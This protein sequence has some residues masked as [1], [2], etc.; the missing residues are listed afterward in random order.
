MLL[1]ICPE[2]SN[3]QEENNQIQMKK[4]NNSLLI[5]IY[6]V[7][8]LL[9]GSASGLLLSSSQITISTTKGNPRTQYFTSAKIPTHIAPASFTEIDV[10]DFC[11]GIETPDTDPVIFRQA[12]SGL[13]FQAPILT[14]PLNKAPP[15]ILS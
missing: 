11:T 13:R 15:S 7:S 10:H 8:G 6:L 2:K 14:L 5:V 9:A 3:L 4:F 12:E 1:H